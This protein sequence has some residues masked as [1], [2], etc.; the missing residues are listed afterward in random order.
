MNSV[1]IRIYDA[2]TSKVITNHFYKMC[3]AEG[4]HGATAESIF[5]AIENI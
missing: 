5:A 1:S 4:E 2:K 3:M